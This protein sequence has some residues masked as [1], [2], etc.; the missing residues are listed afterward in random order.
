MCAQYSNTAGGVP[1]TCPE[2]SGTTV[3]HS[4]HRRSD[5]GK[6]ILRVISQAENAGSVPVVSSTSA[7]L[8]SIGLN[9]RRR[10][11]ASSKPRSEP[12]NHPE[13][14]EGLRDVRGNRTIE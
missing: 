12:G 11:H 2:L 8:S 4:H 10:S 3:T 14:G 9:A 5:K 1:R 7:P 13:V 6:S